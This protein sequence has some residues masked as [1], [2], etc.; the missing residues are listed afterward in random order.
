M[1]FTSITHL[2]FS[3]HKAFHKQFYNEF[4]D[5]VWA[6]PDVVN[7]QLISDEAYFHFSN[8]VN[9]QNFWY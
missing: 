1:N 6:N 5:L 3:L 2:E 8:Y 7:A 4:Q 9:R